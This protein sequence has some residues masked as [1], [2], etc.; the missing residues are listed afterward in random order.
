MECI[1]LKTVTKRL[2]ENSDPVFSCVALPLKLNSAWRKLVWTV[3][4]IQ[5]GGILFKLW[6][7]SPCFWDS[8]YTLV[9]NAWNAVSFILKQI[10]HIKHRNI[11]DN[12]K[13]KKT[14]L[15]KFL[16]RNKILKTYIRNWMCIYIFSMYVY[17]MNKW[18]SWIKMWNIF[19]IVKVCCMLRSLHKPSNNYC[20]TSAYYVGQYWQTMSWYIVSCIAVE[21]VR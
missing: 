13:Y 14:G 2:F 12:C 15:Q 7:F 20:S 11:L 21:K 3:Y 4:R 5:I 17:K 8:P 10:D 9:T 16:Q 19:N 1:D 6:P 18:Q